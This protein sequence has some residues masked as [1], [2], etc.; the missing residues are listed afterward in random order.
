MGSYTAWIDLVLIL[1]LRMALSSWSSCLHLLSPGNTGIHHHM[2][3]VVLRFEPRDSP[4]LARYSTK[5]A[6]ADPQLTVV[7][8]VLGVELRVS[9]C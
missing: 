4:I 6:L 3:Y 7:S 5:K 1:K 9:L 8:A 2:G